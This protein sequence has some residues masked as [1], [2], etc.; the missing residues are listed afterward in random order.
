MPRRAIA[1]ILVGQSTLLREGLA[2]ILIPPKFRVIASGPRIDALDAGALDQYDLRLLIIESGD[3]P[4]SEIEHIALFKREHPLDRIAI[5]G[6]RWRPS[7]IVTAFQ[8]GANVYFAQVTASEEFLKAIEL[9]MLGQT[10]LPSELLASVH[11]PEPRE[12]WN[13]IPPP[14]PGSEQRLPPPY[15]N[16][17]QLSA[18]ER[19]ILRSITKGASNKMI[20]R[21]I[22]ISEA[23]VKVHVKAILRKIGAANRTQAAIWALQNNDAMHPA[24]H[25]QWRAGERQL[26]PPQFSAP[27]IE[28][29]AAAPGG[30]AAI[31]QEKGANGRERTT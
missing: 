10:I 12:E 26:P 9:V 23:T 1:T 20:A 21:E 17:S 4:S 2:R 5:L 24:A 16:G 6:H 8:V 31:A 3:N 19:C 11:T 25:P 13:V 22:D 27:I 14:G 29:E 7:D 30:A 28:C 18:R 15:K